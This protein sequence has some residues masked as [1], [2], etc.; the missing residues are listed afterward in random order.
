[1]AQWLRVLTEKKRVPTDL[2]K[3]LV[4]FPAPTGQSIPTC[5]YSFEGSNTI[6]ETYI[7][8]K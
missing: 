3:D 6:T 4:Q 8:A 5:N 2:P 1:M 7:Q